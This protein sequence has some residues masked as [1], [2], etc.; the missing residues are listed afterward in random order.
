MTPEFPEF[1][2]LSSFG[3]LFRFAS[4]LEEAAAG[5]AD[6]LAARKRCADARDA[7]ADCG[8]RHRKRGG[9]LERLKRERLNEVVLEP[10]SGMDRGAYVPVLEV[11]PDAGC[12]QCLE[13][14]AAVEDLAVRFY[15]DAARVAA[16]AMPGMD[17]I[18]QRLARENREIAASLRAKA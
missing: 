7:I 13:A 15:D 10:V 6:H 5:M 17:R 14:L 12:A 2:E 3:T 11:A 18:L 9:E 8:R 1:P 16:G 4:L